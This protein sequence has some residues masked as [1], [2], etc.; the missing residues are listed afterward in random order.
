M[1]L[2][3]RAR[4]STPGAGARVRARAPDPVRPNRWLDTFGERVICCAPADLLGAGSIGGWAR[5]AL[6]LSLHLAPTLPVDPADL[7]RAPLVINLG[8]GPANRWA[9]SQARGRP[10][11]GLRQN[12]RGRPE[13]LFA[14][15]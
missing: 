5:G 11:P 13:A 15:P 12:C 10:V 14:V 2:K 9:I 8:A 3:V 1:K 6:V 7:A 4:E